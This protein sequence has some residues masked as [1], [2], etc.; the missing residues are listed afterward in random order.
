MQ[1]NLSNM[2]A[3]IAINIDSPFTIGDWIGYKNIEG[4]V[5]KISWRATKIKTRNQNLVSIPNRSIIYE[6][7]ENF[8]APQKHTPLQ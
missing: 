4:E 1:L 8:C 6:K 3:A 2:F 7:V 5:I